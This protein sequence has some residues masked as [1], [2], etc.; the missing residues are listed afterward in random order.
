[1]RLDRY[2]SN[3]GIGTRKEVRALIKHGRVTVNNRTVLD[4]AY[5][6]S[7]KDV[8]KV[9]GKVIDLPEKVYILFYKPAGYV[10]STR[11]PH[12]ETIMEFLSDIK[13]IFPVGRLDK[14]AE[15][16]LL[17][18]NDGEFAHRVISPRWKVEKEYVVKVE[19]EITE[20]KLE[21]LRRGVSLRDGFFAK[22][23]HVEKISNDT[24][25]IVITEGK[26]H[27]VKRMMAAVG[28]KTIHLKRVRI[29]GL[30]LPQE[31]KP[32]E[33]RF[34]SEEEVRQVFEGNDQ[35]EDRTGTG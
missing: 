15:G 27:Q 11:D 26:Y 14:D 7:D 10:T 2:L 35:K 28:L 20:D 6:L 22:A 17:V 16:L 8:V 31:M 29:G 32:G 12:S 3:R 25:K 4:P 24:V 13:G 1:M 19:G 21:K 5:K 23:K 18:T 33:Y 30:R 34:L 9:D